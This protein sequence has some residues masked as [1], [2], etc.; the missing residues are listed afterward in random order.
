MTPKHQKKHLWNLF[1]GSK[2]PTAE[3]VSLENFIKSA[4]PLPTG[5]LEL[6]AASRGKMETGAI[7]KEVRG[8][9]RLPSLG[10]EAQRS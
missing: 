1:A 5:L 8:L 7:V 3:I 6:Q 2:A 9:F 10:Q 4:L